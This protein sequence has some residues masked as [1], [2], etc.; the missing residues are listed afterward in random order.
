MGW[1]GVKR[2]VKRVMH[3]YPQFTTQYSRDGIQSNVF[4]LS[5]LMPRLSLS[6][7]NQKHKLALSAAAH[8][9]HHQQQQQQ[10]NQQQRQWQQQQRQQQQQRSH[11]SATAAAVATVANITS[12]GL[13]NPQQQQQ[14][15]QQRPRPHPRVPPP[16]PPPPKAN[17]ALY[18]KV[19]CLDRRLQNT[20]NS[21]NRVG[22]RRH[23]S[24]TPHS[25]SSIPKQPTLVKARKIDGNK[26]NRKIHYLHSHSRKKRHQVSYGNPYP[27][28]TST[29]FENAL[30][31]RIFG[32]K[33]QVHDKHRQSLLLLLP[34]PPRIIILP[35]FPPRF[36][37]RCRTGPFI[38]GGGGRAWS[39]IGVSLG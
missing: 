3:S 6:S 13:I 31:T 39:L 35:P 1:G 28:P 37:L 23:P 16:P 30:Q 29:A 17:V 5:R 27:T 19:F 38:F 34:R 15:R 18:H 9:Q 10:Q 21:E 24:R 2:R 22:P 26:T 33:R 11:Q 7:E 25:L 20:E 8:W 4:G 12:S 32:S 14:Q 36:G